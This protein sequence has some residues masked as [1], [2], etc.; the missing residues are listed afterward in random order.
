MPCSE[1]LSVQSVAEMRLRLSFGEKL[2]TD[3]IELSGYCG[4]VMQSGN[5]GGFG[6]SC[7]SSKRSS[8]Y[9]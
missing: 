8:L 9:N 5:Y 2:G 6:T 7:Y 3:Y 4:F 1:Y